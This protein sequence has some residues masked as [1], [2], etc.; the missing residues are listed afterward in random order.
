MA[1]LRPVVAFNSSWLRSRAKEHNRNERFIKTFVRTKSVLPNS[2]IQPRFPNKKGG[3]GRL[4]P[5][6][7]GCLIPAFQSS[8]P[9]P[10]VL[11][12]ASSTV[13]YEVFAG[14]LSGS[15]QDS[16]HMSRLPKVLGAF[17]DQYQFRRAT[18]GAGLA[19]ADVLAEDRQSAEADPRG[20]FC[21]S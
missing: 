2:G 1:E 21:L 15:L 5:T 19:C 10:V 6:L 9:G 3:Q 20:L 4:V 17:P 13:V 11:S 12:S 18:N 14:L 16:A 7:V 8:S